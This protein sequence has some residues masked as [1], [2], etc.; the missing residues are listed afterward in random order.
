MSQLQFDADMGARLQTVYRSRDIRRRRDLVRQALSARLGERIIDIG[1][2]PGFYCEE[3]AETVGDAGAVLGVDP[4]A[5]MLAFARRRCE[6]R[7][8]VELRQGD[9]GRLPAEDQSFDAAICV[10]VL[11]YAPDIPRALAEMRR[12]LRP[13]G[14]AVI[15]DVD[16]S[17]VSWRARDDARMVR[18]L[19]AW[20]T[21][22]AHPALP[23]VL[24]GELRDAGFGEIT[25]EGHA[26]VAT[27]PSPDS[28]IGAIL[29]LM[30][31]YVSGAGADAADDAAA[32]RAE[33]DELAERGDFFFACLQFCFT[34][35]RR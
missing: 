22:L 20:D 35:R 11:E 4:S 25:V 27:S 10:Q 23:R 7:A 13:D 26:F 6:G 12:V 5:E 31:A 30:Q 18:V 15:W 32:W 24:A 14:R 16:W 1:C 28:Y 19:K 9:A 2:G 17:T 33:Q 3:L 8:N 29:P 34:A 21:H